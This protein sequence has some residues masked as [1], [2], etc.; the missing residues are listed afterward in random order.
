MFQEIKDSAA[1]TSKRYNHPRDGDKNIVVDTGKWLG[2]YGATYSLAGEL[3]Y[4]STYLESLSTLPRAAALLSISVVISRAL[5]EPLA[6]CVTG[7]AYDG[8]S[9][10]SKAVSDCCSSMFASTTAETAN[11]NNV[12]AALLSPTPQQE[13]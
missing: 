4:N 8:V 6:G 13:L 11:Q 7:L 9:L 5:A 2:Y 10:A 1:K 12:Q 3:F